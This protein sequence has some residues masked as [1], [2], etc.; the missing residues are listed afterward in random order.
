MRAPGTRGPGSSRSRS[1]D[2]AYE[3]KGLDRDF[4]AGAAEPRRIEGGL[5]CS[6][7][8]INIVPV[9]QRVPR[10]PSQLGAND[11]PGRV[12]VRSAW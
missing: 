5:L 11:D 1:G 9:V 7:K 6:N 10:G 2:R 3:K 12:D 8:A 4:A